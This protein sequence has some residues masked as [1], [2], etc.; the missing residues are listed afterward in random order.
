LVGESWH[1]TI[2]PF[3][4]GLIIGLNRRRVIKIKIKT[5]SCWK[6]L[7]LVFS[8]VCSTLSLI[9]VTANATPPTCYIVENGVLTNGSACS[10]NV[11][12]DNSVTSI[13]QYNGGYG[14][15]QESGITSVTIPA[16]VTEIAYGAFWDR[17]ELTSVTFAEGSTLTTIGQFAFAGTYSLQRI[18]LP[19]SLNLVG[20]TAFSGSGIHTFIF[21]GAAPGINVYN[22]PGFQNVY[23]QARGWVTA[24]NRQSF[25]DNFILSNISVRGESSP[26]IF[27]PVANA[28]IEGRVAE[29]IIYNMQ[30]SGDENLSASVSSGTLPPGVTINSSGQIRG[31]PTTAGTYSVSLQVSASPTRSTVVTGIQIIVQPPSDPYF[32]NPESDAVFTGRVGIS[33]NIDITYFARGTSIL[34]ISSGTLPGGLTFNAQDRTISGTPNTAGTFV[35]AL[36]VTTSYDQTASANNITFLINPAFTDVPTISASRIVLSNSLSATESLIVTNV[37]DDYILGVFWKSPACGVDDFIR[38]AYDEVGNSLFTNEGFPSDY[39]IDEED[40]DL[41]AIVEFRV[42]PFGTDSEDVNVNTAYLTAVSIKVVTESSTEIPYIAFPTSGLS[43]NGQVGISFSLTM[44][45]NSGITPE[46][47][48]ITAGALPS[49]LSISGSGQISGTPTTAGTYSVGITLTDSTNASSSVSNVTFVIAAGNNPPPV[50]QYIPPTPVPYLKTLTTPKLN[51]KDGKLVCSPGTYN[52]GYTLDGVIQGSP[53]ALFSP[54]AFTFNLLIN[55]IGQSSNS[56]TTSNSQAVWDLPITTSGALLACSVAVSANSITN[57]DRSSDN[58]SGASSGLSAQSVSI[59]SANADFSA[60]LSANSKAYQK[61][62]TDNRTEWRASVEKNRATYL[63]ELDRIKALGATKQTRTQSSL[64]LKTYIS[65]QKKIASD[66]AA[67]K[68]AALSTKSAADISALDVKNA[69]TAK[70]NSIYAAFI[71]SI[72]YGV[73]IP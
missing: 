30:F 45:L 68:P 64:A 9:P 2:Y 59:A 17:T 18:T 53:T 69:A 38:L 8:I 43:F 26:T 15:F 46:A 28:T 24:A 5:L 66:Y 73:M 12:I 1:S 34:S 41:A 37:P 61:A 23:S 54:A 25:T 62:L 58:A 10:G 51:L 32:N 13:G 3:G 6:N 11:V 27:A 67:S 4:N 57:I 65:T 29:S 63:A 22:G 50:I 52:A 35:F 21:D 7:A 44:Q 36:T 49:G 70:A 40:C 33:T 55:G 39:L 72:G 16:S 71:E 56:V 42:F 48:T 31:T 19:S 47:T 14:A 60:Q 20:S